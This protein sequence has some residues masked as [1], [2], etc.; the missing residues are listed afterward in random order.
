MF[1][2]RLNI[3]FNYQGDLLVMFESTLNMN[4]NY[5][6]DLYEFEMEHTR[7]NEPVTESLLKYDMY[8]WDCD[9]LAVN[10][11]GTARLYIRFTAFT[12]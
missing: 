6:G 4:F 7:E 8:W 12:T 5:Q 9:Q 1:Q 2:Y 11:Y 3:N 10:R